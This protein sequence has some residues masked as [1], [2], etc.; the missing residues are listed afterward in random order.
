MFIEKSAKR[1]DSYSFSS[2]SQTGIAIGADLSGDPVFL[3]G[4]VISSVA[5]ARFMLILGNVV[6]L[7]KKVEK[8]HSA[9]Q[10]WV[11]AQYLKE[12][13]AQNPG[14]LARIVELNTLIAP[15][16]EKV[17][18]I[19][20]EQFDLWQRLRSY[21]K[22]FYNWLYNNNRDA[23]LV[24]DPIVSVQ[25]DG[26]FF[27]AFSEDESVYA[28]VFLP[29]ENLKT[30]SKP[31]LGTTNIDY[32]VLLEREFSRVRSYRPLD[33]EVGLNKVDISTAAATVKEERIPLPDTW[34][35]GL[36]EVQSV[37]SLAPIDFKISADTLAELLALLESKRERKSPRSL[38]FLLKPGKPIRLLIEPWGD[39]YED[40]KFIYSGEIEQEI[41]V[42]GRRRLKV[43]RDI[44]TDIDEVEVR[45]I[46]SGMP[47]F[48]TV[49][50]EG[51]E[52]TVGLSSWTSNDWSSKAKFSALIP[53]AAVEASDLQS[54]REII[55]G[56]GVITATELSNLIGKSVSESAFILQK[57]CMQGKLMFDPERKVFRNRDLFPSIELGATESEA[58]REERFGIEIFRTNGIKLTEDVT[59]DD[60]RFL[61]SE[62]VADNKIRTKIEQDLDA[63]PRYAQCSCNFFSYNKLRQGPCRHIVALTLVGA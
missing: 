48:W 8:D 44:L 29:H 56:Q 17:Q 59:K 62:L 21:K 24:L 36:V 41:R 13:E 37:L 58:S 4:K 23:W 30:K 18:K 22:D 14:R 32:S 55:K 16:Q 1:V 15:L 26:T 45:L 49:K 40:D 12:F 34:V 46:G 51:V 10:E 63:R 38:R 27:E 61:E 7:P 39:I 25:E 19:N 42:W 54:A 3:S 57:L 6:R 31:R 52:L 33:L 53:S 47:T 11:A 9:Y 20:Q 50:R 43:L 28:R 5:F 35:R 2:E 60:V